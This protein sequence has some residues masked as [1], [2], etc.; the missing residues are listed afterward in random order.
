[1]D[2]WRFD[3]IT[4][5]LATKTSRR[6][7]LRRLGGILGATA[8]AG[9]FP[10]LAFASNSTCAHFCAA[11]FGADTPAA[12]QCTSDA[13][14]GKGLCY[15][16]GPASAGGTKSICCPGGSGHCT[17]YSSAT[18]CAGSQTCCGGTCTSC[19]TGG[20]CSGSSC[21]CPAGQ[22]N[23]HG[24]CKNTT[25][26][27]TNCGTCGHVCAAGE[28][29]VSGACTCG[30][31]GD[32][33]AGQS[34]CGGMCVNEQTDTQN[35]GACGHACS[36]GQGCCSGTCTNLTTTSNCGTCGT[37]CSGTTPA[38]CSGAC[39]DLSNDANNC[40]QCGHTCSSGQTCQNGTCVT[41]PTCSS[42]GDFCDFAVTCGSYGGGYT[43]YCATDID[44]SN[45]CSVAS[46]SAHCAICTSD[47][48]CGAGWVCILA[49]TCCL[50]NGG[51]SQ[52]TF[53]APHC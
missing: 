49:P 35:C 31:H 2:S 11:V 23:C 28:T 33:P 52:G 26:D 39:K 46:R 47:A 6:Q 12:G 36:A 29:C 41:L 50:N 10:G 30:S 22:S 1:M 17:S 42:G 16:C 20:V 5:A 15:T 25:S 19:P 43:C 4:K 14:H 34:C 38:C 37:T 24:T 45:V 48:D 32:C 44:G 51:G 21:V 8:L 53:C 18:C 13:A 3:E 40:G 9:F 7:T 27:P